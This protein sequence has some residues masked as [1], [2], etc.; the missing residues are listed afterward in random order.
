MFYSSE[1]NMDNLNNRNQEDT[2]DEIP[3]EI[4]ELRKFKLFKTNCYVCRFLESNG[5]EVIKL[6]ETS[7]RQI[8][9][10]ELKQKFSKAMVFH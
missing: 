4:L 5:T 1:N 9:A 6:Y 10:N 3:P 7:E 2:D 8:E